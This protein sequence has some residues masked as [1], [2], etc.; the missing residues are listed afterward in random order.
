MCGFAGLHFGSPFE[1]DAA[2]R[3]R[4]RAMVASIRHRG[5]DAESL[6]TSDFAGVGFRR[7]AIIDLHTGDQPVGNADGSIQVFFNGEIYNHL[8]LRQRL[9]AEIGVDLRQGS[10]AVVLP[11]LYERHGP[12]FVRLLNGMFA[13]CV[14]D[15]RD[16]SVRL[17]RDQLGV[18]P[19]Y[20]AAR[21]GVVVFGSELKP[22]FASGLCPATLD[23][24]QVVPFLEHFYVPGEATLCQGVHKLMPGTELL[25]LGEAAPRLRTWYRLAE[26]Q[27]P[28][29]GDGLRE[30]DELLADAVRRQ[31]VADVPVGISLS[32]GLDSSLIAHYARDADVR[33]Y[34]VAFPDTDPG[35]LQTART[36][37]T[38]L[39]LE[40]VVVGAQSGDF[41][42]DL[43]GT[44]WFN[45]EPVADPAFYPALLVARAAAQHVKVL[46]AGTGADEL[47]AGYGHHQLSLRARLYRRLA[48]VLGDGA[49]TALLRWRATPARRAAVR[50]FGAS[51]LPFH[52]D[53]MTHLTAADRAALAQVAAVDHLRELG[54]AFRDAAW[55][56]G[57]N[58][59]LHA[60]TVTYLPHQLLALL[61]RTTMA[62]SIEGR[63]PLLDHRVAELA[64]RIHGR[65]KYRGSTGN[66]WLLRRLAARHLPPVVATRRKHGFP[67]SV[68]AWLGPDHRA[69]VRERLTDRQGVCRALLPAAWLDGL[70]ADDAA[71]RQNAL[72]LHSLLVLDAW[73][74]VFVNGAPQ[75]APLPAPAAS[76]R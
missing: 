16:R 29:P 7:L 47:F 35:E 72:L 63:V 60:D 69:T 52:A 46:L 1:P 2:L 11:Y 32:G 27:E 41:L 5:P 50:R 10:D 53:A 44:T 22:L 55:M 36:V 38:A 75:P 21:D 37:A 20:W 24:T 74:R 40:H 33:A 18:K 64:F 34:T 15:G 76:R 19:L 56:D 39:G 66:K 59:Q 30:L 26:R 43:D 6:H 68:Q 70:L 71:V 65:H 61:D 67:S 14:L 57:R 17:Y 49:A 42:Q 51:R 48:P 58:Q 54:E 31:L 8:E 12:D 23:P 45:D 13:I 4:L 9:R 62:A 25:L 73:H 28:L 3:A